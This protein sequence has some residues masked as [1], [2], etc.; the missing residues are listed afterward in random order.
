MALLWEQVSID[1][2]DPQS[3]GRWWCE[4]L[5]WQ[6]IFSDENECE[7]RQS[8]D[9]FPGLLFIRVPDSKAGKNGVNNVLNGYIYRGH[10]LS[11]ISDTDA[12]SDQLS[13]NGKF[14]F[15]F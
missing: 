9:S 15:H 3:L 13:L 14:N 1:A 8:E 10:A 7:I 5:S 11:R 12:Y 2:A 4:A 6:L